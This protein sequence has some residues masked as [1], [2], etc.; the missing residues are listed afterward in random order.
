[1]YLVCV[2]ALVTMC[3]WHRMFSPLCNTIISRWWQICG[4]NISRNTKNKIINVSPSL[5]GLHCLCMCVTLL[6]CLD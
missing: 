6:V 1:M 3:W 5:V 2:L 4:L